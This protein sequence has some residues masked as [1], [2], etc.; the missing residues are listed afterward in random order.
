[1]YELNRL[2]DKSW[3]INCYAK[4]GIYQQT[5]TDVYIIDSG[6]D[7]EDAREIEKILNTQPGFIHAMWCGD[8]KCE[9]E[10]KQI[11]G[12]KSRCIVNE[13]AIDEKCVCCGKDAKYHVIWGIQY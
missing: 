13:K 6:N 8:I 12:C 9:E 1:M 4:V 10:I 2:G 11:K 7:D 5:E 3:Y